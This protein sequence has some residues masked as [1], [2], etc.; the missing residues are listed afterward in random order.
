MS[1]Y[2]DCLQFS[3]HVP[4]RGMRMTCSYFSPRYMLQLQPRIPEAVYGLEVPTA[5]RWYSWWMIVLV[6]SHSRA[7]EKP[8]WITSDRPQS[9]NRLSC[10]DSASLSPQAG[11]GRV[12]VDRGLFFG[13]RARQDPNQDFWLI[14]TDDRSVSAY[15]GDSIRVVGYELCHWTPQ[16]RMQSLYGGLFPLSFVRQSWRSSP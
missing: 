2:D 11:S 3:H 13:I 4:S 12:R 6:S 1:Q 8:L 5:S 10:I 7:S 9:T 15:V 16:R 14:S